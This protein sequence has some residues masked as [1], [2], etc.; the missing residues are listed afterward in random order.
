MSMGA[1]GGAFLPKQPMGS[2][3][4]VTIVPG[5]AVVTGVIPM[6]YWL[7]KGSAA[8]IALA[9]PTAAQI[10]TQVSFVAGTAFAHVVTCTS[11]IDNGVTGGAKSAWTSAAFVG[12]SITL[13]A[14]PNLH[15][16]V[17]ALVL[18]AVA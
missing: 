17:M 9:A 2:L 1:Q 13:E 3:D 5:D 14:M 8:A 10:G 6:T 18:G 4:P 15:W 12:S 11:A 16:V 7:T